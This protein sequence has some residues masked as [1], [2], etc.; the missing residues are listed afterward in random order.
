MRMPAPLGKPQPW[1]FPVTVVCLALG[2]LIATMV[3]TGIPD[4]PTNPANIRP[5][6]A[7]S[8]Y[9]KQ[10][11]DLKSKV[12]E[13]EAQKE[14]LLLSTKDSAAAQKILKDELNSLR[15]RAGATALEGPGIVI[16]IDDTN[17]IKSSP[18]A[19]SDNARLTHDVDLLLLVNELRSAGTEA[20]AINDQRV[21]G[22]SAIRCVG[23][24]I[25][26]NHF[27]VSAPFVIR[28]IG[29]PDVLDGAVN[30]P[31]GVLDQLKALG[32]QVTVAKRD[33]IY[34]SPVT[35]QA[36]TSLG[37]VVQDNIKDIPQ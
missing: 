36:A 25:Q 9:R 26:V 5:E 24:V 33:K 11:E 18:S 12:I 22:T 8:F 29:K 1:V 31:Y 17:V 13:L 21:V 28:A 14:E 3:N 30:L 6:E 27:P 20:V 2:A 7:V 19:M 34:V 4:T 23:P 16:T 32:I 35:V 10:N 37:K 15:V